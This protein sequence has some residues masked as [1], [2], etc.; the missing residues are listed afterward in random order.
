MIIDELINLDTSE[1][2]IADVALNTQTG[3]LT[4]K[5][6]SIARL[7]SIGSMEEEP[8]LARLAPRPLSAVKHNL[9]VFRRREHDSSHQ[10][11]DARE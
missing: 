8:T 1:D 3:E 2:G 7:I 6:V 5:A 11:Q 9:N 4:G 10:E